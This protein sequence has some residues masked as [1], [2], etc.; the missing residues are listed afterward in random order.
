MECNGLFMMGS[1]R[2][3]AGHRAEVLQPYGQLAFSVYCPNADIYFFQHKNAYTAR[4]RHH[5]LIIC[6]SE[7][8]C[9]VAH[10]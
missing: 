4:G 3:L 9:A 7:G 8:T 1:S 2:V 10:M 6:F 5:G